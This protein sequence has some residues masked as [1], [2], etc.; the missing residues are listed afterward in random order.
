MSMRSE[1]HSTVLGR[2]A[3][4]GV[5][6]GLSTSCG[7]PTQPVTA[8]GPPPTS[9][10]PTVPPSAPAPA[11]PFPGLSRPGV[12]YA[13]DDSLYDT[14]VSRHGSRL[15]SRYV[16][17]DDNSFELQFV[18]ARFGFFKYT[19]RISRT[20]SRIT[21]DW[22]GWSAAGPWAA[23]GTLRGDSL[24]VEYNLVMQLTDFIDGVYVR[25][26]TPP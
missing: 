10:P 21:F 14:F 1:A 4:L 25:T 2:R 19:G 8:S 26:P 15:A 22:D 12:I 3:V 20:D 24:R 9:G 6:L 11:P 18:G 16:F 13:G 5:L 7:S 17:Y 23:T